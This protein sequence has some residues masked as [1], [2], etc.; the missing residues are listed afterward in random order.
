MHYFIIF[1]FYI[2]LVVAA[3]SA[4]RNTTKWAASMMQVTS[5]ITLISYIFIYL[6]ILGSSADS[7]V[8]LS[9]FSILLFCGTILYF[10]ALLFYS[11]KT[12][13]TAKANKQLDYLNFQL[14]DQLEIREKLTTENK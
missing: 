6:I 10:I 8:I 14:K 9:L 4:K 5:I 13:A 2:G 1:I 12:H 3:A 7:E 11:L